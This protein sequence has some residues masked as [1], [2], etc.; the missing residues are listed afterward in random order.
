[1]PSLV[2]ICLSVLEL[3]VTI[4]TH[5]HTHTH[6]HNFNFMYKIREVRFRKHVHYRQF[7]ARKDHCA[8][9]NSVS[10]LL[11]LSTQPTF[12]SVSD[13]YC[14]TQ[15]P[16]RSASNLSSCN[17]DYFRIH[18]KLLLLQ[19]ELL[20]NE[21]RT[22]SAETQIRS[23]QILNTRTKTRLNLRSVS[24]FRCFDETS[25]LT[26]FRPLLIQTGLLK[27][28]VDLFYCQPTFKICFRLFLNSVRGVFPTYLL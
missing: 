27:S 11:F 20:P 24:D 5:S 14:F 23:D 2:Q 28:V 25:F 3:Q 6:T 19:N 21:R 18:F 13:C 7:K 26:S 4:R 9:K 10:S 12:K 16:T 22:A 15:P 17:P 8:F 1:M